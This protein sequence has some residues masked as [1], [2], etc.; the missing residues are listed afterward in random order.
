LEA[1]SFTGDEAT[2]TNGD[3][4]IY[5]KKPCAQTP[6]A[7]A[8][9]HPVSEAASIKV[10]S[11]NLYWWNAFG[12]NPWKG[13]QIINNIKDTM[14]PDLLGVQECNDAN[15]IQHRTGYRLAS[16]FADNQGVMVNPSLF[17]VGESGSRDLEAR[18]K[19]G[20]RYV[21]WAHVT[22]KPS[23]RAFWAF[24]T[25]WCVHSGHGHTCG[26]DKRY[27]GAKN[28]LRTI[29]EKAGSAPV[30]ITGDFNAGLHEEA[31]QHFLRNGFSLAKMNWVDAVF[32]TTAH[33]QKGH[34]T[35]GS[36]AG[37]DHSPVIAELKLK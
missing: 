25:H 11:Y 24:N 14:K 16:P 33:W 21:T 2:R 18:G 17:S 20:N 7:P 23:G 32:Y 8:S 36:S 26:P 1:K 9:T 12:Q 4:K 34:T 22:H 28:M 37:S 30:I 35:T 31:L 29:Q 6:A 10:A 19:W 15:L 5:Y 13:D 27:V 3:F